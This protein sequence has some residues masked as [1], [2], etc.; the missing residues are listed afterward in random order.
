MRVIFIGLVI[1]FIISSCCRESSEK[2][3][4]GEN[5][6][7][8]LPDGFEMVYRTINDS[9]YSSKVSVSSYFGYPG[10]Y[11][12]CDINYSYEIQ[13]V[14]IKPILFSNGNGGLTF[15]IGY[16]DVMNGPE[17]SPI[18]L[19]EPLIINGLS[20]SE[21]WKVSKDSITCYYHIDHGLLMFEQDSVEW[22]LD[23]VEEVLSYSN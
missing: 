9:I 8:D 21:V 13:Y 11:N 12:Q 19:D 2:V 23:N 7:I 20:F 4:L 15:R 22:V 5:Q 6:K 14:R 18:V 10:E 17:A 16:D 3:Y 1:S